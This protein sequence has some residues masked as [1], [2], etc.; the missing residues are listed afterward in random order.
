MIKAENRPTRRATDAG[1]DTELR[2]I[3]EL[4]PKHARRIIKIPIGTYSQ[5]IMLRCH[6]RPAT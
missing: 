1:N 6:D 4:T 3:K 2:P 5:A